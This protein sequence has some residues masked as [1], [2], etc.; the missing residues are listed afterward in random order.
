MPSTP[1][2]DI[3]SFNPKNNDQAKID[4]GF[5]VPCR[6]CEGAFRRLR[7]TLRYCNTCKRGVCEGEHFNF[8]AQGG[9]VG[10]CTSCG[11]VALGNI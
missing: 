4:S 11:D 8:A 9:K 6:I 10:R 7:L 1:Q 3:T 2:T 5:W